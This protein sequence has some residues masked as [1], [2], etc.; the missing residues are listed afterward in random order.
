MDVCGYNE[1]DVELNLRTLREK[2]KNRKILSFLLFCILKKIYK[3]YFLLLCK[4]L[5]EKT[6]KNP[7]H[8]GIT[9]HIINSIYYKFIHIFEN[10]KWDPRAHNC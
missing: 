3:K 8:Q 6:L 2:P 10:T 1:S 4:S 9:V 7:L 5:K